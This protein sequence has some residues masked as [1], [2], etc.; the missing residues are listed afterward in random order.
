MFSGCRCQTTNIQPDC[1]R[2]YCHAVEWGPTLLFCGPPPSSAGGAVTG[3]TGRRAVTTSARPA[4][5]RVKVE[6]KAGGQGRVVRDTVTS[7]LVL[8]G[9]VTDGNQALRQQLHPGTWPDFYRSRQRC[10]PIF[11]S[12]EIPCISLSGGPALPSRPRGFL[13]QATLL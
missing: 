10:W 13:Q 11:Q 5:A 1:H 9:A 12:V 8:T 2:L 3:E 4:L 7:L 6:R